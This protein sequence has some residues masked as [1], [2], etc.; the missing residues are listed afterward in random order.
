MGGA[1]GAGLWP[2]RAGAAPSTASLLFTDV[3]AAAGL[4]EARNVSGSPDDKQHILEEMG[5]GAAF[6]DYDND[7]W[8]DLMVVNGAVRHLPAQ[9]RAGDP[10]P[11]KQ[12][13]QLLRNESGRRFVDVTVAAG[14]VFERLEVARGLSVGDLDNDGDSDA[15]IFNNSGPAR[16]LRNDI[17]SRQH[18]LGLRVLDR[19]R[20]AVQASVALVRRTGVPLMRRVGIDAFQTDNPVVIKALESGEWPEVPHYLQPAIGDIHAPGETRPWARV[21]RP[22]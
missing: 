20:D 9:V 5:G 17:G 6:F 10:Y 15:V 16:V 8:L 1:L 18:W 3:T 21:K 7:G 22:G 4:L 19:G 13:S 14:P 12:R 2:L 11:L